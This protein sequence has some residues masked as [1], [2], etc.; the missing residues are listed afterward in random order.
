MQ[1]WNVMW[2]MFVGLQWR[3]VYNAGVDSSVGSS[4]PVFS[5]MYRCYT[6]GIEIQPEA[7]HLW[8]DLSLSYFYLANVRPASWVPS[9]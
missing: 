1:G 5:L 4:E 9:A 8:H 3:R 2:A 7:A 6:K